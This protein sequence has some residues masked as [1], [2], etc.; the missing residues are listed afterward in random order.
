[1]DCMIWKIADPHTTKMNSAR[2]MGPTGELSLCCFCNGSGLSARKRPNMHM[3]L[4]VDLGTLPR[5]TTFLLA[6]SLAKRI[7]CLGAMLSEGGNAGTGKNQQ[8]NIHT[9]S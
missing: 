8:K 4:T 2:I 6:F 9:R 3:V 7:L 5:L 1:M